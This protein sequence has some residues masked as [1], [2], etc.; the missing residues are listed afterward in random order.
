MHTVLFRSLG[1]Q[2]PLLSIHLLQ[3]LSA[4]PNQPRD[5]PP[6]GQSGG[7]RAAVLEG[8]PV[9]ARCAGAGGAAVEAAALPP[10]D[11]MVPAGPATARPR[12]AA[13][14]PAA[15]NA[16]AAVWGQMRIANAVSSSA[17][18]ASN[19]LSSSDP[20]ILLLSRITWNS[21]GRT[22][23]IDRSLSR[24]SLVGTASLLSESKQEDAS[25]ELHNL[26][27]IMA[28]LMRKELRAFTSRTQ[29]E[30]LLAAVQ[31]AQQPN[32]WRTLAVPAS[33]LLKWENEV[34]SLHS[35]R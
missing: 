13:L 25:H 16:S 17:L 5:R 2:P 27:R 34:K 3:R 29:Y 24:C 8:V 11:R 22:S 1:S 15:A 23:A 28:H 31:A 12:V 4:R 35:L 18:I 21:T 20:I 7:R 30:R 33:Q 19:C 26:D 6:R 14:R 9:A 32:A 10:A